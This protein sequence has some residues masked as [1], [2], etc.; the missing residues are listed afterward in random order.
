MGSEK[1]D[2]SQAHAIKI[3]REGASINTA[4]PDEG[5][6]DEDLLLH[7]GDVAVPVHQVGHLGV[8][9]PNHALGLEQGRQGQCEKVFLESL[10][11]DGF[12]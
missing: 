8:G 1:I 11:P 3:K 12:Y 10:C 9:L 2:S 5:L 4:V 6:D 7:A